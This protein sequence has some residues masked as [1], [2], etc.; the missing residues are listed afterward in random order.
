VRA[1]NLMPSDAGAARSGRGGG[2]PAHVLLAV[3][4][5]MVV[6]ASLWAVA[7][8]QVGDRRAQLDSA[9]AEASAA[10][11][12]AGAAAPY[13]EFGR[14][15]QDRVAT[16]S[17]LAR[18]RFDWTHAM[19]EIGRLLPADVWLTELSGASG[20]GDETP[21]PTV[22]VAPSPTFKLDGCTSSQ[23][24]VAWLLARLRAVDG[25]RDVDLGKSEKPE[26]NGD[27][28][29]PAHAASD[30]RFTITI[31]FAGPNA[32]KDTLDAAGQVA[33]PAASAAPAAT[34]DGAA[35]ASSPPAADGSSSAPTSTAGS[36][37]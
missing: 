28:S 33:A 1:V 12:R 24:R 17:A 21:S 6:L 20:A 5:A 34:P 37:R 23:A 30:P 9:N 29:C 35:S 22:S 2:G 19:R 8:R 25:V 14:L 11:A 36:P 26:T 32:P 16:V 7:N 10:E 3:L 15:A 27:T 31:A 13:A 18:S 4:A